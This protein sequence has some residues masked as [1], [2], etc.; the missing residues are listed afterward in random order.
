MG[1]WT[2]DGQALAFVDAPPT[3]I[4]DIKL[5]RRSGGPVEPLIAGPA[6]QRGPSF[7]P[8]GQWLAY[9]SDE[10]GRFEVYVRPFPASGV[11]RSDLDQRR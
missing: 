11:P 6:T 9:E 1:S 2:P 8:D 7:S 3:D 4:S 10:S 5:L